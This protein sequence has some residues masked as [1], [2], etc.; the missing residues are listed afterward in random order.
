MELPR[1]WRDTAHGLEYLR[2]YSDRVAACQETRDKHE[3]KIKIHL[4]KVFRQ[5]ENVSKIT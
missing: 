4:G 5:E 2:N 3:K 1:V